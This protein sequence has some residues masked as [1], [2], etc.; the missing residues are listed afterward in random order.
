MG[1]EVDAREEVGRKERGRVAEKQAGAAR[2]RA[3]WK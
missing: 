3:A 2:A 1:Q